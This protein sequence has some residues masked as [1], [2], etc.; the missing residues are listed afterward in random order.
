M[1][2]KLC[3]SLKEE[4]RLNVL[5]NRVSR[6]LSGSMREEVTEGWRKLYTNDLHNLHCS[7]YT[8]IIRVIKSKWMK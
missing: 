3:L 1:S 5:K 2:V 6:R 7:L 4:H 8:R